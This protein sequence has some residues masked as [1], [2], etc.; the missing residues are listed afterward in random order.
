MTAAQKALYFRGWAAVALVHGWR[1]SGEA[2]LAS[3]LEA[4]CSPDLDKVYQA[5]WITALANADARGVTAD[6]MRRSCHLVAGAPQSSK[7]FTHA[8]LDRVLNLFAL[9]ARPGLDT[10]L[11]YEDREAGERRRHVH[12]IRQA[13]PAYWQ[14]ICRDRFGHCDLD[15]LTLEQLRQLSLTLRSRARARAQRPETA[16]PPVPATTEPAF[17]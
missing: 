7:D 5:V 17:A 11:R 8:D 6:T 16:A 10:V 1:S 15:R 2:L 9:L 3:R 14:K 13:A 12:V 4:W